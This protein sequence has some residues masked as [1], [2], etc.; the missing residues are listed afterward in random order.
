MKRR[1]KIY[2]FPIKELKNFHLEDDV[3]II[4]CSS[5]F[6]R[7]NRPKVTS[8]WLTI[9]L[10]GCNNVFAIGHTKLIKKFVDNLNPQI[11]KIFICE[12]Q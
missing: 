2:I 8:N 12:N 9:E 1:F 4:Y 3:A 7:L 11:K 5:Y 6:C 10:A